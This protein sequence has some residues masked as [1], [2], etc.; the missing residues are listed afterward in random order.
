MRKILIRKVGLIG[1]S[2]ILWL[3]CGNPTA[4][5]MASLAAKGYYDHLIHG[6]YEQYLQG[7]AGLDKR[8]EKDY[9]SQLMDNC[10]QFMHQQETAQSI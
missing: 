9:W 3:S 8:L 5:E 6:E 7:K 1:L 4:E 10:H 2:G